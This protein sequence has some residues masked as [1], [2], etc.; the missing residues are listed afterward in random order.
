M[1][2]SGSEANDTQVQAVVKKYDIFFIAEEVISAF[3]RF[4]TMFG[5]MSIGEVMRFLKALRLY[6]HGWH[7]IEEHVGTKSAVQI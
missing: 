3:G 6:G 5:Y 7:Q 4:G 1:A 2:N